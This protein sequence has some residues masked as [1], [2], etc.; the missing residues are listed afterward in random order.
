[1]ES[2]IFLL[3]PNP[4]LSGLIWFVLVILVMYFARQPA[5]L[6]FRSL[7]KVIHNAMRLSARSV[8]RAEEKLALRNREVIIAQGRDNIE[9]V[10]EREFEPLRYT[11]EEKKRRG[12][13]RERL[14]K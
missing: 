8:M 13:S 5:H 7:C 2:N 12:K 11:K 6:A 9:R 10:I 1:M 4:M 14:P 3:V